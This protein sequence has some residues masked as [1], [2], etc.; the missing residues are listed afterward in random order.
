MIGWLQAKSD[1]EF[2]KK[3]REN[4]FRLWEMEGRAGQSLQYELGIG[5][6]T[7]YERQ[8]TIQYALRDNQEYQS[9]RESV[10]TGVARATRIAIQNGVSI[11]GNSYPPPA[12]GGPVIPINLFE[13]VLHDH[14]YSGYNPQQVIGD[15]NSTVS[16]AHERIHTEFMHMINPLY[17]LYAL[18][19]FVIRIPFMLIQMSGFNVGKI[20]DHVV[21]K[22]FKLAEIAAIL[23]FLWKLG[24]TQ[25]QFRDLL[26]RL[27]ARQ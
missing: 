23:Y 26:I 25:S 1:W 7:P 17:W 27:L 13:V 21:S 9:V 4:V 5:I 11:L 15:L 16:A 19:R 10:A 2:I 22:L 14:S 18:L 12:V 6:Q 8:L 20:E 24:M 3:F